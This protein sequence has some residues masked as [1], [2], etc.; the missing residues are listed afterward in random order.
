MWCIGAVIATLCLVGGWFIP[1]YGAGKL[2]RSNIA[3]YEVA[4]RLALLAGRCEW[5]D[6]LLTYAEVEWDHEQYFRAKAES[7]FL[8]R[9]VG[10]WPP[11]PPRQQIRE[12][13]AKF[14]ADFKATRSGR[15]NLSH[16][17]PSPYSEIS[18]SGH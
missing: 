9:V 17:A 7:H 3:E 2:E 1:M 6:Q 18:G 14:E 12:D 8:C 13:F 11:P 15:D 16:R 5:A 10:L 4:A